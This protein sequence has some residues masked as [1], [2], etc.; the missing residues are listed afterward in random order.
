MFSS[1]SSLVRMPT[2][3]RCPLFLAR[4]VSLVLFGATLVFLHF[5]RSILSQYLHVSQHSEIVNFTLFYVTILRPVVEGYETQ[6]CAVYSIDYIQNYILY[7]EYAG[8]LVRSNGT[9]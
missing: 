5:H 8:R 6:K 3:L 7:I 1:S 4:S 2:L 9:D